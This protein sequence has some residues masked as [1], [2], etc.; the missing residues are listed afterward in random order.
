MCI[1]DTI[2]KLNQCP[3]FA[4]SDFQAFI[5][6]FENHSILIQY[7]NKICLQCFHNNACHITKYIIICK[8]FHQVA[9]A[10]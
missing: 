7:L 4:A 9:N 2:D 10:F 5:S 3:L 6:Y 1:V 8:W